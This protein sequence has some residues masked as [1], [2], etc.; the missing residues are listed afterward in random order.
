MT[1]LRATLPE[2][3]AHIKGK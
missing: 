3:S 1:K 2:F